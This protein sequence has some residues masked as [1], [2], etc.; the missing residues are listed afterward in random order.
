MLYDNQCHQCFCTKLPVAVCGLVCHL[1]LTVCR[2][3]GTELW[4]ASG[5]CA[6]ATCINW[7]RTML[8]ATPGLHDRLLESTK[9]KTEA[10]ISQGYPLGTWYVPEVYKQYVQQASS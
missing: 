5:T 7:C 6:S 9:P 10:L 1:K 4:S 8:A 2:L 3:L